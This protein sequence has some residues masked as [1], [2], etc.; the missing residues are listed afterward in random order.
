ML[1]H[2]AAGDEV[3]VT[4][5]DRLARSTFDLFAIVKQIADAGAQFGPWPSRGPTPLLAQGG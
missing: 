1:K 4:L 3:V 2:V 5:I